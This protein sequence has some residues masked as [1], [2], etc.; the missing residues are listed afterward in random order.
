MVWAGAQHCRLVGRVGRVFEPRD[1]VARVSAADVQ[2]DGAHAPT[3]TRFRRQPGHPIGPTGIAGETAHKHVDTQVELC[4][5]R[6]LSASGHVTAARR[7]Y[8]QLPRRPVD[9]LVLPREHLAALDTA[10]RK[11]SDDLHHHSCLDKAPEAT[12][13]LLRVATREWVERSMVSSASDEKGLALQL[14][15]SRGAE[16]RGSGTWPSR[17][18][19]GVSVSSMTPPSSSL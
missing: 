10:A 7:R 8:P 12:Q 2:V 18:C 11:L 9:A 15:D 6:C 4:G 5:E 19:G 3:G 1:E 16:I 14:D 13:R 17:P